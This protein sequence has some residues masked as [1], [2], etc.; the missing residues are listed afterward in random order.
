[1]D[2]GLLVSR[3]TSN[4]NHGKHAADTRVDQK[5]NYLNLNYTANHL[6]YLT[7]TLR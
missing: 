2:N 1:M 5:E 7:F 3:Q 6:Y 4:A